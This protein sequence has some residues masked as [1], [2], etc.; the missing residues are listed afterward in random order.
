MVDKS[1]D[2]GKGR[3]GNAEHDS[4]YGLSCGQRNGSPAMETQRRANKGITAM[5][6]STEGIVRKQHAQSLRSRLDAGPIKESARG[7]W[8]EILT[9]LGGIPPEILD[10]KHHRC[11]KGCAP[12]DG[13]EDRY[14]AIDI[15]VGALFCNQCFDRNNGDGFAALQWLTGK[16]FPAVVRMVAD[17][18]GNGTATL[19]IRATTKASDKP[20]RTFPTAADAMAVYARTLGQPTTWWDYHSADGRCCSFVLRWDTPNGKE[21]RPV[22]RIG[23]RWACC[24]MPQPRPLYRLPEI[25]RA[26][27]ATLIYVVEG[28]KAAEAIWQLRLTA[29]TSANGSKSASKTDWT[30]L[31]GRQVVILP[32][33]DE[34][35]ER[36][37]ANVI[38]ILR[39]LTPR[40]TVRIVRLPGLPSKGDAY[41]FIVSRKE[42]AA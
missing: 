27:M 6:F 13:G 14:R 8:L 26:D 40:P 9:K 12:Y 30:P 18:L 11:P 22:S 4:Q 38:D 5:D 34:A 39:T 15:E 17:L 1:G 29:T 31:A 3:S 21:L 37:T 35:G 36:Y 32:D 16:S 19:G 28:E 7:R 25:L 24:G 10:G 2:A 33:N 41:D 20:P 23:D 42:V